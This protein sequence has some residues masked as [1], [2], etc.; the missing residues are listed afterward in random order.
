MPFLRNI[1]LHLDKNKF[2]KLR[3]RFASILC[4]NYICLL[5]KL[6]TMKIKTLL[7]SIVCALSSVGE[8]NSAV[9]DYSMK[10]VS[11][12]F[13]RLAEDGYQELK[14]NRN[15][16]VVNAKVGSAGAKEGYTQV[17]V[18]LH[19][20]A[21]DGECSPSI[22]KLCNKLN[23]KGD[24]AGGAATIYLENGESFSAKNAQLV[25]ATNDVFLEK[26]FSATLIVM[27]NVEELQSSESHKYKFPEWQKHVLNSFATSNIVKVV[28][29][30]HT[31]NLSEFGTADTLRSMFGT[32]YQKT[33]NSWLNLQSGSGNPTSQNAKSGASVYIT[34]IRT[35]HNLAEYG[36]RGM[37]V[38]LDFTVSGMKGKTGK[39]VAYFYDADSN[40]PLVDNNKR[41]YT[42]DGYVSASEKFSSGSYLN[43]RIFMPL[44]E[45][46][47]D[48]SEGSRNL[49]VYVCFFDDNN[50]LIGTSD[51]LYFRCY[52]NSQKY[53][54]IFSQSNN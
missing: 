45:L 48:P 4:F 22:M 37:R 33:G 26:N 3:F 24:T 17:H 49:K 10:T 19:T 34:K 30:G 16:G 11:E 5:K 18:Y 36:E 35:E 14:G 23:A 32:L 40:K 2:E 41:Y 47:L 38:A 20:S 54:Y 39:A 51:W 52:F 1:G 42:E 25:N 50:K 53:P 27:F 12:G 21:Y 15:D 43:F 46:D 44:K 29:D 31:Y 28:V 9:H 13:W 7:L 8:I 6:T